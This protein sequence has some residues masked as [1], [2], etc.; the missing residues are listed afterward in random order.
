MTAPM[1]M[2]LVQGALYERMKDSPD[3]MG[4]VT[5]VYDQV[6]ETAAYPYVV[7]GEST[8]T[9][10]NRLSGL[11]RQTTHTLHIWSRYEGYAQALQIL[12]VVVALFDH[13][14]LTVPGLHHV[15]T[16]YEFSQTLT[17][18]EPPGSLRHVPVRFRVRTEQ[19][20]G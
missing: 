12:A 15:G 10:D 13:Q 4:L 11:G 14:P 17:D 9:P 16:Y 7:L 6:P 2:L 19:P 20:S 3:L 5:G 18:P 8:E 1:A